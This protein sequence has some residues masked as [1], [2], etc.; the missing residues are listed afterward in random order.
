LYSKWNDRLD[1]PVQLHSKGT[2]LSK[3]TLPNFAAELE[4][5]IFN[6]PIETLARSNVRPYGITKA[7]VDRLRADNIATV[8]DL[9]DAPEERLD[10]IHYIGEVRVRQLKNAVAQAIWL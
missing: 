2:L 4:P 9:Y 5:E 6:D 7:I 10:D 3:T 1:E 8:R